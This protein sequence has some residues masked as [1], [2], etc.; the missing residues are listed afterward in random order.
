MDLAPP[1]ALAPVCADPCAS[2]TAQCADGEVCRSVDAAAVQDGSTATRAIGF[3]PKCLPYKPDPCDDPRACPGGCCRSYW[4]PYK[5]DWVA[6]CVDVCGGVACPYGQTCVPRCDRENGIFTGVCVPAPDPCANP[7]D[8]CPPDGCCRTVWQPPASGCEG[9]SLVAECVDPCKGVDCG[10]GSVCRR[11]CDASAQLFGHVCVEVPDPCLDPRGAVKACPPDGC[12]KSS[13]DRDKDAWLSSCLAPC[14]TGGPDSG[15]V[16]CPE[17]S[18]CRQ[19]CDPAAGVYSAV[20]VKDIVLD[21]T[22]VLQGITRI[23]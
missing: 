9:G 21:G 19:R 11:R 12:C 5:G 18:T 20:C 3:I 1:Y 22:Q 13:W 2:P 16:A 17:G 6:Q 4:D 23:P 10:V 14:K 8:T 7:T 15:P